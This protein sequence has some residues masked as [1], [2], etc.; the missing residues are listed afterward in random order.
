[1]N[2]CQDVAKR[3]EEKKKENG[4]RYNEVHFIMQFINNSMIEKVIH[5]LEIILNGIHL[6]T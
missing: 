6:G 5:V 1:M 2:V 3:K 4:S